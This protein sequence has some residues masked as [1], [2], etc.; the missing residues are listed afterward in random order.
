MLDAAAAA[1]KAALT[2][3]AAD[4]NRALAEYDF[5]REER[6]QLEGN[7]NVASARLAHL[8]LL[9]PTVLLKPADFQIVPITLVPQRFQSRRTGRDRVFEPAGDS[10]RPSAVR[11]GAA[12]LRQAQL[13]PLLPHFDIS[14]YGGTFGGGVNSQMNDFGARSDG[15]ADVYWELHNLAPATPRRPGC[16]KPN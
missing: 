6:I 3:T 11:C 5:R 9:R 14:Y 13:A 10:R 4:I 8:L 15:E 1:D 16:A 12:R 2:K 7:A